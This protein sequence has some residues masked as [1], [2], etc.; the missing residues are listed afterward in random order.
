MFKK[1]SLFIFFIF[2]LIFA[3][4]VLFLYGFSREIGQPFFYIP[5]LLNKAMLHP[6]TVK[7]III[8]GLDKRDDWLEKTNTTDTIILA[9]IQSGNVN[10]V[11][12]PRDLWDYTLNTKINQIYPQ[13]QNNSDQFNYIQSNYSRITG[14]NIDKTLIITTQNLSDLIK[15]IG[16]VDVYLD[17]G[18]K[19]EKYPNPEYIQNPKSGAPIYTTIEFPSGLVHL[20]DTNITQ[21]VRSRKSAEDAVSGGTDIGRIVRQQLVFDAL[22]KKMTNPR[23]Y[24]NLPFIFK[25]YRYWYTQIQTNITDSDLLSIIY[26]NRQYIRQIKINK[27]A[28]TDQIYHPATFINPQ[29][30]FLPLNKNYDA[31]RQY[32]HNALNAQN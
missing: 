10:L 6:S 16:G 20:D 17:K 1:I 31:F 15:L 25:M 18:F 9:N 5:Q 21:F 22:F 24:A 13:S 2:F 23:L 29:W 28:L 27:I 32:I 26:S 11:S 12:L 30:V 14:Q 3:T 8:L 19:D 4:L 7:N